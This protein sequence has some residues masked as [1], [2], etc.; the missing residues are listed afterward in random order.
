LLRRVGEG[1]VVRSARFYCEGGNIGDRAFVKGDAVVLDVAP[2]TIGVACRLATRVQLLTATP[3]IAIG[4]GAEV[5]RQDLEAGWS[6]SSRSS[7]RP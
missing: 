1:V 4:G 3:P 6:T 7:S 5:T 2:V